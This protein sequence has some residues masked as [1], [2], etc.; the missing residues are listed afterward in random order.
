[1]ESLLSFFFSIYEAS[2]AR[3]V[4]GAASGEALH[5]SKSEGFL[6]RFFV[7]KFNCVGSYV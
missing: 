6:L 3:V 2:M 7:F 4:S 5:R 1:M